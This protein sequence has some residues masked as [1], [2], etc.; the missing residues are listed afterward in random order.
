MEDKGPGLYHVYLPA[1]LE[2]GASVPNPD[3]APVRVFDVSGTVCWDPRLRSASG[4][5][6]PAGN[7]IVPGMD[8]EGGA[9]F[10]AS[11]RPA[12]SL[13]VRTLNGRTW[14]T[15]NDRMGEGFKDNEGYFEFD[16]AVAQR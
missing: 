4:C 8:A 7:G 5:N 12:G 10:V 13:L 15:V 2:W 14:F 9:E 6:G 3:E 1:Q 16:V 11:Q